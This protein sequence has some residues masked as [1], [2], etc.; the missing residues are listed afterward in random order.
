MKMKGKYVLVFLL[1]FGL[2][3]AQKVNN[4][5]L[6]I[7]MNI[8]VGDSL[9]MH[10]F[11]GKLDK[12]TF[13]KIVKGNYNNQF[14]TLYD[15]RYY[16]GESDKYLDYDDENDKSILIFRTSTINRIGFLKK[17]P[18]LLNSESYPKASSSKNLANE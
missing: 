7:Q 16:D 3:S 14:F 4:Q 11:Y 8:P 1:F 5:W 18:L 10:Y 13:H 12:K 9:V 15:V 6:Y 2:C 17:D